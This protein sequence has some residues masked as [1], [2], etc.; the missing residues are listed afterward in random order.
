VSG[1]FKTDKDVKKKVEV[2]QRQS[3]VS[4]S[5]VEGERK[6]WMPCSIF[7]FLGKAK[8]SRGWR[9]VRANPNR[10]AQYEG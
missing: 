2:D 6:G 4:P 3:D 8:L 9:E 10:F 1:K 5:A 7:D